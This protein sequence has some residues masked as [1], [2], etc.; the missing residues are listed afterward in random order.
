MVRA[1]DLQL[2]L[3][4]YYSPGGRIMIQAF[5]GKFVII[6]TIRGILAVLQVVPIPDGQCSLIHAIWMKL[7]P[8]SP[9]C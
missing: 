4:Y 5:L 3:A 8:D 2:S 7:R 9:C 1:L 6:P